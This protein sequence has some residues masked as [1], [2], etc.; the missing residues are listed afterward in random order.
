MKS[1]MMTSVL[2]AALVGL[3]TA[4]A[5]AS[6]CDKLTYLTF[7]GPVGLPGVTL[8]A[9]TYQFSHPDCSEVLRVSS[10]DG[11]TVY[12]TFLTAQEDRTTSS[13]QTEVVLAEM[14]VGWAEVIKAWFYSGDTTG[15][16]LIF[17]KKEADK[18]AGAAQRT[19]LAQ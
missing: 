5:G 13:E 2:A 4:S 15:E 16:A 9:G 17:P 14:P 1:V 7:S 3:L 11:S 10:Q 8:P 19:V 6:E 18:V 12:G